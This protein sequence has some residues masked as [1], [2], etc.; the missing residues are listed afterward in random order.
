MA[1]CARNCCRQLFAICGRCDRGRRY[2]SSECASS[3]RRDQTRRAGQQY[4]QSARGR[5]THAMRQARYRA[6][7]ADVTHQSGSKAAPA[8]GKPPRLVSAVLPPAPLAPCPPSC[9]SCGKST[10]FM[11]TGFRIRG[12]PRSRKHGV[13]FGTKRPVDTMRAHARSRQPPRR[14]RPAIFTGELHRISA[15]P[16]AR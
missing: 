4:Q 6:R 16:H 8:S 9:V 11:R 2:C 7:Q 3:A 10:A 1:T 12:V 14:A 15:V 5:S 13:P